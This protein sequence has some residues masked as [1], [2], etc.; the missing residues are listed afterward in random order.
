MTSLDTSYFDW[1]DFVQAPV[2]VLDEENSTALRMNELVQRIFANTD[3]TAPAPLSA[4]LGE[5]AAACLHQF[6]REMPADGSRNTLSITCPTA[7]G[8]MNLILHLKKWPSDLPIWVVTIDERTLF[9]QS[10][11]S[12]S[13][14]ET[15]RGIIQALPIGIDILNSSLRGIFYNAFSDSLYLYDPYYDLD[16]TEWF[17]RAFPDPSARRIA[18]AQWQQA[19]VALE[20]DPSEPQIL[21]W[22]VMCRD[23]ISRVLSKRISKIG[24]YYT[25]IY[26][27]IT[28]Q[29]QLEDRLRKLASTDTLTGVYNR[30]HFFDAADAILTQTDAATTELSILLLDIDHF[31][32]VNDN[33][34]HQAGDQ[35]L[36]AVAAICATMLRPADILARFGGEEFAVL[37]PETKTEDAR[38]VAERLVSAVTSSPISTN[39]GD[40][41]LSISI[42]LA[43]SDAQ[44][45]SIDHLIE[46]ADAALYVAKRAGRNQVVAD[47]DTRPP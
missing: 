21:E 31:K 14:E 38:S 15:F 4:F 9:F 20:H 6:I 35:A 10:A 23:G 26:W 39:A 33:F 3:A 5:G 18:L 42:G 37:L 25:F 45:T 13:A 47:I 24:S 28:E 22:T 29:R 43:S 17:E 2:F 16:M 8:R 1:L 27:D 30:R 41:P 32:A 12:A 7:N 44:T 34:G 36:A 11:A 46:R 40:L 19:L